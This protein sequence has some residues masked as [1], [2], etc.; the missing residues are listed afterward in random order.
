MDK[1]EIPRKTLERLLE[2]AEFSTDI[3][4]EGSGWKSPE[5]IELINEVRKLLDMEPW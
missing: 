4:V 1:I 3:G 5:L 2:A